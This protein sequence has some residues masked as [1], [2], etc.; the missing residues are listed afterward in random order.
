[1]AAGVES[2]AGT[3]R[4]KR[5]LPPMSSF[6]WTKQKQR[7]EE[8]RKAILVPVVQPG[9]THARMQPAASGLTS[10]PCCSAREGGREDGRRRRRFGEERKGGE[11]PN[12]WLFWLSR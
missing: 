7:G 6:N 10:S 4:Q 1:M 2:S 3:R 9:L 8:S 11:T 12:K 5:R